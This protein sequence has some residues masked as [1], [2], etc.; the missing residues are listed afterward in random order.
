MTRV[1]LLVDDGVQ[2]YGG[3]KRAVWISGLPSVNTWEGRA[4]EQAKPNA[5]VYSFVPTIPTG[6]REVMPRLRTTQ[7][8]EKSWE[9][10]HLEPVRSYPLWPDGRVGPDEPD[11]PH[12]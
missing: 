4:E 12:Q 9:Q 10:L 8:R 11:D 2:A 7:V 5:N 6:C 1:F 3:L